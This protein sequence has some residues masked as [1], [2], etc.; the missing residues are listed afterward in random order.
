MLDSE[1]YASER[2]MMMTTFGRPLAITFRL[3]IVLVC[4]A[5]IWNSWKLA[6]AD[7]L[8]K[9]DTAEA[10]QS[11]VGWA[12]DDS[13]AY[14]RLAQLDDGNSRQLLETALRLDPYNAQADIELG[15]RYEADG[16]PVRA[17]KLLL[18]AFEVDRTYLPRWS[19]AN[20][21][22][23][24]DN[25]PAFW[26]W[27]HKASEM[28]AD[29]VGALFQL[30]WQV[31]PNPD[32][33]AANLL[34]DDPRMVHQYLSFLLDKDQFHDAVPVASRLM[35]DGSPS[36]DRALL[37]SAVN[38]MAAANAGTEASTVWHQLLQNNWV[39]GDTTVP[40]NAS[41]ARS[42]LPVSF[43]WEISSF[44]G[45][46]SWPG[47]SG[48]Q[49][50]FTG[51]EPENCTVAKQTLALAPG[52]YLFEYS[53]HTFD[54]DPGSGIRWQIINAQSGTVLAESGDLASNTPQQASLP[55]TVPADAPLLT[56]RLAYKRTLGTT[57]IS[58]TLV[59][60]ST[61]IHSSS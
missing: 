9:E 30:C 38:K 33:I 37:L 10:L 53:F 49:T 20:F 27:A 12:P 17:E 22:L 40:N 3:V 44:Q 23:R 56:L 50:D 4:L 13:A 32:K 39:V 52:K 61:R 59:I 57:R 48:L 2:L 6:Y 41:F 24:Q 35:R 19:L 14:M 7:H 43:D 51:K 42:P 15:L 58:G 11:A 18:N 36:T 5:G 8:V 21:Y 25:I 28:P 47:P 54:I 34:S 1:W 31:S 29:E 45:L 16:D 46:Y 60:P 26:T 55:F